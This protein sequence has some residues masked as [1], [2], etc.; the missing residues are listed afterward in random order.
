MGVPDAEWDFC[1]LPWFL[2][3]TR[4]TGTEV[5]LI[6]AVVVRP[7]SLAIPLRTVGVGFVS[8]V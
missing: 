8:A 3:G 7:D 1:E 2:V 5:E 4:V 6:G